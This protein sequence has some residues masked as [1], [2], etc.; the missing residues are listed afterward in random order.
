MSRLLAAILVVMCVTPATVYAQQTDPVQLSVSSA[1]AAVH[2][3]P[4]TGSPVVG[5]ARRG[6]AL[7]VT[8]ELGDWVRVAWPDSPDGYGYVHRSMG[9]LVRGTTSPKT[10]TQVPTRPGAQPAPRGGSSTP[11][12]TAPQRPAPTA[13]RATYVDPPTHFVGV[14]GLMTGSTFGYGLTG[15]AWSRNWLGAQV[16]MTRFSQSSAVTGDRVTTWQFAP[17]ALYSFRDRVSDSVWVKPYVGGGASVRRH[18]LAAAATPELTVSET[19]FSF[20]TF[21]GGEFTLPSVP[22]F[23]FSVDAGYDWSETPYEGYDVGG[24]AFSLSG[25]W[26]FK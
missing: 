18:S 14:G 12:R 26:Y 3:S 19:K 17:S 10:V 9:R 8:R 13:T 5:T 7:E 15:R 21:G 24:F 23:A 11:Q 4:S 16:D 2:K 22:R 20:Q 25:R 1:S 6:A